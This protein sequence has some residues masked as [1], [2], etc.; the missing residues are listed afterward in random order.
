MTRLQPT[1]SAVSAQQL[2]LVSLQVAKLQ[3][4]EWLLRCSTDCSDGATEIVGGVIFDRHY[5]QLGIQIVEALVG[6]FWAFGMSYLI[7]STLDCIPGLEVLATDVGVSA[8]MDKDQMN[9][10]LWDAQWYGE[11]EYEPLE[12]AVSLD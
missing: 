6:F 1:V 5:A 8:G 11:E 7:I 4:S 3:H 9:E 10:S 12:G 2:R